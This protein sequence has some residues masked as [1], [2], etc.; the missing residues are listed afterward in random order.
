LRFV[1]IL[2]PC[3]I[4]S[5]VISSESICENWLKRWEFFDYVS[6]NC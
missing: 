2:Q 5:L 1:S 3:S 4:Y 6:S